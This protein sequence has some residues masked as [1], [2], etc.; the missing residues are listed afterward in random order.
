LSE[1]SLIERLQTSGLYAECTHCGGEFKLAETVIFDGRRSFPDIA[2]QKRQ[3][4]VK[5]L[6]Q[7]MDELKRQKLS[8]VFGAES[9]VKVK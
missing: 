7:R 3:E 4:M 8:A 2:E 6:K 9:T 1:S 5:E